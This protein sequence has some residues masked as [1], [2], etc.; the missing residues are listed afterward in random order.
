MPARMR[1]A[2]QDD[3]ER[4]RA[5]YGGRFPALDLPPGAASVLAPIVVAPGGPYFLFERR[6]LGPSVFAGQLGFP[7]GAIEM[8][9][10][11]PL[12]A[13]L[14]EAQEEVGFPPEAVDVVGLLAE[15]DNH[16]GRRVVAYLGL[17]GLD[18][19]PSHAASPAEVSELLLVPI[20][21]LREPGLAAPADPPPHAYR[22]MRYESRAFHGRGRPLHYWHMERVHAPGSAVL[23]GLTGEIVARFLRDLWDWKPLSEPRRVEDPAGLQP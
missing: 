11:N 9:D 1:G 5:T 18:A 8:D 6:S 22:P 7:G 17:L 14:R 19:I 16:L 15:L 21:G 2:T 3:L 12:A 4:I 13:A 20:A 10:A 23:W